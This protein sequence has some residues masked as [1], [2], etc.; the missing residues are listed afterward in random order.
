MASQQ[1]MKTIWDGIEPQVHEEYRSSRHDIFEILNPEQREKM[2]SWRHN[3]S[4]TNWSNW[5]NPSR[6]SN[7][8]TNRL[9]TNNSTANLTATPASQ[10]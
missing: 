2:K 7:G 9:L 1:R 6:F 8:G 4:H 5:T 3:G 10:P